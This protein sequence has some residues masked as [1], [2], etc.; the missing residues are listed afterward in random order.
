MFSFDSS[1]VVQSAASSFNNAALVS[2]SFFWNALL[3]LPLFGVV[4]M[5]G[6]KILER[7]FPT[8]K[9]RGTIFSLI[10]E[11]MIL[12]WLILMPGNYAVL[13]DS[14]SVLPFVIAGLVFVLTAAIVQKIKQA[15][16]QIPM[17]WQNL[18]QKKLARIA[19]VVLAV[20]VI[21]FSGMPTWYGFLM[22][23]AAVVCGVLVG[24]NW[25]RSV[26]TTAAVFVAT[27]IMLMQPEFFRFGQL[28][29]L[30]IIH[31]LFI[32][33]TGALA[34]AII[35]LRN[36]KPSNRIYNSAF[37]KLKWMCR[38]VIALCAILFVLTE[39]VLVFLALCA[40]LFVSFA[41]SVW[42]AV[43][44]PESLSK[45]LWALMLCS[46]G[47]MASLPVIA[48]LGVLYWTSLPAGKVSRQ[49]KF[50]L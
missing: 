25:R 11:V 37:I 30:T 17:M 14:V 8:I 40:V 9:S 43:M 35:A 48:A 10:A 13:R 3:M 50:L 18:K 22:Q 38:I 33:V 23:V 4:Y 24:R 44:I 36:I 12:A 49:S 28:G 7:F 21:G 34:M 47:V 19:L 5:F 1:L 20:A 29:N 41:M 15:N 2:P 27:T 32:A 39:S 16:I 31:L 46:F 6:D 45:K 42:H 26:C